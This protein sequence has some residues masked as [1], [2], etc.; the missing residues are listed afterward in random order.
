MSDYKRLFSYLY[1]YQRKIKEKNSGFVKVE[2]RN[3]QCRLQLSVKGGFLNRAPQW[4]VYGFT[5][6]GREL[7]LWRLGRMNTGNGQGEWA[8]QMPLARFLGDAADLNCVAGLLLYGSQNGEAQEQLSDMENGETGLVCATVWDD[9]PLFMSGEAPREVLHA[10]QVDAPE[11]QECPEPEQ[12]ERE[13]PGQERSEQEQ[14]G[15]EQSEQE[16]PGP[17]QSGREWPES[18]QSGREWSKP[19]RLGRERSEQGR[20]EWEHPE[21]KPEAGMLAGEEVLPLTDDEYMRKEK[22]RQRTEKEPA[23]EQEAE[24]EEDP[25]VGE[26]R[27]E[28]SESL[29]AESAKASYD[30]GEEWDTLRE[31][32]EEK[33]VEKI[34]ADRTVSP[35][36]QPAPTPLFGPPRQHFTQPES[37]QKEEELRQEPPE[38]ERKQAGAKPGWEPASG[39]G[40]PCPDQCIWSD[41]YQEP[42]K[43]LWGKLSS[44]YPKLILNG[45][46]NDWEVLKIMPRDIGRL[47]RENWVY[48]NN[49][50]LLHGYYCHHHLILACYRGTAPHQYYLGVPGSCSDRERVMASMFGFTN[51]LPGGKRGYWYTP[52]NLGNN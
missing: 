36:P 5:R 22:E 26:S 15:P 45:L 42:P 12:S 37:C 46:D 18:E 19:E 49:S 50:F 41:M 7:R 2:I 4:G 14:L 40:C 8:V 6:E 34:M 29:Q 52:I 30:T 23:A 16:Q 51:Y 33:E 32:L 43:S 28:E 48:G 47:P 44:F 17:E 27:P 20:S 25:A 9:F 3:N 13:W 38:A 35:E 1:Y 39:A 10:A 11:E 24:P 21:E 31:L